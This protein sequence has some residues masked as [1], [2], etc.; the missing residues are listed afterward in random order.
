MEIKD[1]IGVYSNFLT[2][3]QISAFIRSFKDKEFTDAEVISKNGSSGIDKNTRLVQNYGLRFD[4]TMT[5]CHWLNF[6]RKK[7]HDYFLIYV[8]DKKIFLTLSRMQELTLLKY[9]PGGFYK[10]HIDHKLNV[11]NLAT[12]REISVIIFL[13]NDYKGGH[14]H[15]FDTN[16][17]EVI[18]DIEP[19]PGKLVMWPSNFLFPHAATKVEEG[20]RFVLVSWLV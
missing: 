19:E 18:L 20:T 7:I 12:A 17:K 14:L 10:P 5:E 6:I 13:N 11:N 3:Q 8:E 9:G 15:F 4:K 1:L 16:H 2:P